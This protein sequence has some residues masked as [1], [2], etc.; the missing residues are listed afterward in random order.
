[1]KGRISRD[2]KFI[3]TVLGAVSGVWLFFRWLL[4]LTAPF[5]LAYLFLLQI[6]PLVIRIRKK[7]RI[8]KGLLAGLMMILLVVLC[9]AA[10]YYLIRLSA[11]QI[12]S[13]WQNRRA[14]CLM[15]QGY[16]EQCCCFVEQTF[17]M[18]DGTVKVFL[19]ENMKLISENVKTKLL[20]E[21]METSFGY[22]K[23]TAAWFGS[24]FVAFVAAVFMLNDYA[25]LYEKAEKIPYF[26]KCR[27][28]KNN[29]LKGCR[30]FVKAQLIIMLLISAVCTLVFLFMGNPY[31]LVAGIG[32]GVLDALPFFGTGIILLPWAVIKFL[33]GKIYGG[34][35]LLLLYGVCTFIREFLEPKLMGNETG[36]SPLFF[37]A[38]VYWGMY[39][40]GI[41]GVFIGPVGGLLVKEI[42]NVVMDGADA[43]NA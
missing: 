43:K 39:L 27:Q 17:H 11:G 10:G 36:M 41:L 3:L 1:M 29:M 16:F 9:G 20:P 33:N 35:L 42:V 18:E 15:G 5:L 7:V 12:G 28:I 38:T 22:M 34:I 4:P 40:F 21:I 13:L 23:Q 30:S 8:H 6:H 25:V 32:V 31:C 14:Y 2:L 19:D 37:L 26:S 24:L